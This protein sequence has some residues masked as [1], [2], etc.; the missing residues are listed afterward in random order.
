MKEKL[1]IWYMAISL[2]LLVCVTSEEFPFITLLF[3]G[4]FVHGAYLAKKY[5]KIDDEDTNDY[6]F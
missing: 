4:M 2:C 5:V 3:L 1:I 6:K